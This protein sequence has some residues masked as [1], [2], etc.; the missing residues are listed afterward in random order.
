VLRGTKHVDD[1]VEAVPESGRALCR[2]AIFEVRH[3][4]VAAERDTASGGRAIVAGGAEGGHGERGTQRDDP[5][6][7]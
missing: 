2:L 5:E 7:L 4:V 1:V 6:S 3:R